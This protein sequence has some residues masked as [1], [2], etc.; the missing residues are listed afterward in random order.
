MIRVSV[1]AFATV[2]LRT[3]VCLRLPACGATAVEL[4][5]NVADGF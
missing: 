5:E 4:D 1:V 2:V 3:G